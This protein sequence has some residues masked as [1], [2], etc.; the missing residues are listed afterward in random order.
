MTP[1]V[2]VCGVRVLETRH[3]HFHPLPGLNFSE[4]QI[5]KSGVLVRDYA[6]GIHE[7]GIGRWEGRRLSVH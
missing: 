1:W 4:D 7:W 5:P 2:E 3:F 6:E